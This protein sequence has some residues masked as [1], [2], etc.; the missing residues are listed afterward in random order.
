MVGRNVVEVGIMSEVEFLCCRGV[1]ATSGLV[2][3]LSHR[4][5]YRARFPRIPRS[6]L[7]GSLFRIDARHLLLVQYDESDHA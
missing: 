1:V 7:R 2:V 5:Y 3:C 4:G 6:N